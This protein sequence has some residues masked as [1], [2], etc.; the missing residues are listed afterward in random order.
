MGNREGTKQHTE[1]ISKEEEK[2]KEFYD[3]TTMRDEE[4]R[5]VKVSI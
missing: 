5:F 1:K 3:A 4:G 2:C